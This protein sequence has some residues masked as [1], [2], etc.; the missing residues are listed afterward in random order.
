MTSKLFVFLATL[1]TLTTAFKLPANLADGAY[2]VT[3]NPSTGAEEMITIPIANSTS[4]P[5]PPKPSR[6]QRR[7]N[8]P[9]GTEPKC[10]NNFFWEVDFYELSYN[11]FYQACEYHFKRGDKLKDKRAVFVKS[12]SSVS[13]MCNYSSKGNPCS[14]EEWWDAVDKV[15]R[16]CSTGRD[17]WR[18]GGHLSIP[19][20]KKTYG[21]ENSDADF[22]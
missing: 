13:Y 7:V 19:S 5:A 15:A 8:W 22:C 2:E 4:V 10:A 18:Q 20:W 12:G 1:A 14:P 16:Q 21:F 9:S 3:I 17:G 6:L 11:G